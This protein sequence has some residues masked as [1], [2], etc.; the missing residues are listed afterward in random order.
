MSSL[1]AYTTPLAC[2]GLTAAM[3]V[4]IAQGW[5][6]GFARVAQPTGP[7]AAQLE[8]LR[9]ENRRLRERVDQLEPIAAR[10]SADWS[11]ELDQRPG[12]VP[13]C[14]EDFEATPWHD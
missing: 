5:P 9:S 11:E 6:L 8:Q 2:A 14:R 10:S 3:F 1:I 4:M 12:A 13:L 7:S